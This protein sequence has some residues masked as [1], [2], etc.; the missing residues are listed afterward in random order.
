[1]ILKSANKQSDVVSFLLI[2]TKLIIFREENIWTEMDK[3][4]AVK[5]CM[6]LSSYI[7]AKQVPS[8][9]CFCQGTPTWLY[10]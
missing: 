6:I 1:M 3:V 9:R 8:W 7:F 2:E 5:K 10:M 4:H